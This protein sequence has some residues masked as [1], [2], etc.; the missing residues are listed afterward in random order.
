MGDALISVAALV[1]LLIVLISIDDRVRERISGVARGDT[2]S[3]ELASAR[4]ELGQTASVLF[5]AVKDQS[6][7]HA[8]LMIFAV[9]GT[10]LVLAML[11][12]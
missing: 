10:V 11:R 12:L 1:I 3:S 5:V 9:V 8:P 2:V 6:I 7:E 4:S